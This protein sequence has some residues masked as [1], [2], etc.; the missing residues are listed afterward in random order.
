ME[1]LLPLIAKQRNLL[2]TGSSGLINNWDVI[3]SKQAYFLF[4]L[5]SPSILAYLTWEPQGKRPCHVSFISAIPYGMWKMLCSCFCWGQATLPSPECYQHNLGWRNT[6]FSVGLQCCAG[7][8]DLQGSGS[9]SWYKSRKLNICLGQARITSKGMLALAGVITHCHPTIFIIR[10]LSAQ[11]AG[12]KR[13][14]RIWS[15]KDNTRTR[16]LSSVWQVTKSS[17]VV[18]HLEYGQ[19][20]TYVPGFTVSPSAYRH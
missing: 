6:E 3:R 7:N 12:G 16:Q 8:V 2:L 19:N 15:L 13:K 20:K 1:L 18:S 17:E 9:D 10:D 14:P 4:S 11:E 5:A